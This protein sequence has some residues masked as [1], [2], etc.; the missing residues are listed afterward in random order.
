MVRFTAVSGKMASL[1]DKV[2]K[3]GQMVVS[4]MVDGAKVSPS[5]KVSKH[6]LM[7]VRKEANGTTEGLKF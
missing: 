1:K 4:T 5:A 3:R 7:V 2:S 6:M